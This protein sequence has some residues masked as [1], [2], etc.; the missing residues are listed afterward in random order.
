MSK[1]HALLTVLNNLS[2]TG[3]NV[4]NKE[5]TGFL[6]ATLDEKVDAFIPILYDKE[7]SL[8]EA[9]NCLREECTE[10]S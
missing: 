5:Q 6:S 1:T 2:L 7:L 8:Q 3:I 4:D 10:L 9:L